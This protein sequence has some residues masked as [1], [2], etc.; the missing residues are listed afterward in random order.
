[1]VAHYL[2][3]SY[4]SASIPSPCLVSIPC[5]L[6]PDLRF[7]LIRLTD[8][9]L[10][11]ACTVPTHDPLYNLPH[12]ISLIRFHCLAHRHSLRCPFREFS[13]GVIGPFGHAP[14]LTNSLDL[15]EVGSLPSGKVMLS[16]PSSVTMNPSDF[17]SGFLLDFTFSAYTIRYDG[18]GPP[19]G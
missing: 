7:S 15:V 11:V 14:S 13:L 19:T 6:E 17:S 8:N 16:L 9:L 10:P 3:V 12:Q 4:E 18:C 1:V 2:S 5:H